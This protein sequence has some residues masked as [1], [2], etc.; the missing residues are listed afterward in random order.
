MPTWL[1]FSGRWRDEYGHGLGFN[2][3]GSTVW[4]LHLKFRC[5]GS[6]SFVFC[7]FD[8]N[9]NEKL[10]QDLHIV[11]NGGVQ[12]LDALL[13]RDYIP[14]VH[15]KRWGKVNIVIPFNLVFDSFQYLDCN[16]LSFVFLIMFDKEYGKDLNLVELRYHLPNNN[17]LGV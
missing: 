15:G 3:I 16:Q 11:C 1:S 13:L 9:F 10:T 4:C 7:L 14:E 12:L 8:A 17:F 6:W 5:S 2:V